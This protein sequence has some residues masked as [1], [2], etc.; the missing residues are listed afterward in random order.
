MPSSC[1]PNLAALQPTGFPCKAPRERNQ[2]ESQGALQPITQSRWHTEVALRV[3]GGSG[4]RA[5]AHPP[6][7]LGAPALVPLTVHSWVPP[8]EFPPAEGS[9]LA[10]GR[11]PSLRLPVAEPRHPCLNSSDSEGSLR[12]QSSWGHRLRLPPRPASQ[13]QLCPSPL[14][15][16]VPEA[17]PQSPPAYIRF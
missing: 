7:P 5:A 3:G 16:A 13:L 10:Q 12:P 17:T 1:A 4:V 15:R 9:C 2:P 8:Q 6:P 11:D 14:T